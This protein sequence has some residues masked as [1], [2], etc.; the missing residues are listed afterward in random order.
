VRFGIVL[1]VPE[2]EPA[3]VLHLPAGEIRIFREL[4]ELTTAAARLFTE[5]AIAAVRDSGRFAVSLAGGSTPRPVY[6]MLAEDGFAQ[7]IPW[8]HVHLFWGDDRPVP[9]DDPASN[10]GMVREAL[11]RKISIPPENVHRI[12]GEMP[13]EQAAAQYEA[14]LREFFTVSANG[15][16]RFDLMLLGLGEDGHT[17]SLFP[18]SAALEERERLVVA[19]HSERLK[20][21]RVSLTLPVIDHAAVIAFLVAGEGKR[22]VVAQVLRPADVN[23]GLPA[24]E[25][26]AHGLPA[27]RV[28]PVAGKA[29]WLLDQ[30]AAAGLPRA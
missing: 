29:L 6:E 14:T 2:N 16:P 9:P 28:R 13:A 8:D 30:S 27:Q 22:T 12:R 19:A 1:S 20:T 3:T 26:P 23:D 10:Y 7:R 21:E 11:L 15:W 5:L 17:A 18:G 4:A 25:L 24:Q